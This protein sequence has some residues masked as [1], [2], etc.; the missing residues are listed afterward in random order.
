M[1]RDFQ[2]RGKIIDE[3]A[4]WLQKLSHDDSPQ[5]RAEFDEWA[6][7]GAVHVE[8][9]L[10]AHEVWRALDELD[11]SFRLDG[12]QPRP[13]IALLSSRLPQ[14]AGARQR[15]TSASTLRSRIGRRGAVAATFML[16]LGTAVFLG[17]RAW[18]LPVYETDVG[19][20]ESIPLADGSVAHLNTRTK[21]QVRFSDRVREV[22]LIEGEALFKVAADPDRPF[23][24]VTDNARVQALG[25]QFNVYRPT[26][27]ATRVSVVDGVVRVTPSER[28]ADAG[29]S[30]RLS[31][32]DEVAIEGQ[33]MV[34]AAA[35]DVQRTVAW[36]SRRLIF[37]Q[38]R[39]DAI[40]D[41][42]NRYNRTRIR[43]EG[44]ALRSRRMGGTFD[45]DDPAPLL[46]YL[47]KDPQVTI[48]K[49]EGG[50]LIH[51]KNS[52]VDVPMT[53]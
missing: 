32:G 10:Q 37:D 35:P 53:H 18:R 26:A 7:R 44:E 15:S 13:S 30:S 21:V 9:L 11:S 40:A 28:A 48:V 49:E 52:S 2:D 1:A 3:A 41:E 25:T 8:E 31:S 46:H 29:S 6:R 39:L 27:H 43:I 12:P 50:I 34:R 23:I 33:R 17:Y 5:L 19:R 36:R 16:L 45:A 4:L 14:T 42:F 24:V 22:R 47:S 38:T 51:A 20:Q